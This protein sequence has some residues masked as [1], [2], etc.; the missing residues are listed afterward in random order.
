V[1]N[2]LFD[3]D[4]TALCLIDL[5][6]LGTQRLAY[7]MGDALRSWCNPSGED[8][9]APSIDLELLRSALDGYLNETRDLISVAERQ[10]IGAGLETVC[11]ELAARFC[12]DVFHDRYFGWDATRFPSRRA[13]N[14]IRAR[15]QLALGLSVR[16]HRA[17]I[18][19]YL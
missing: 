17:V 7:E 16:Q 1:S 12:G 13:H 11:L 19:R 3:S 9:D 2:I 5:D 15:G 18:E 4:G 8:K 10:S 6:T 14:L